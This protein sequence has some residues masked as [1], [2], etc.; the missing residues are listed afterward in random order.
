MGLSFKN[1][2]ARSG[3]IDAVI[4][5]GAPPL[6]PGVP[7]PALER[8]L[9]HGVAVFQSLGAAWLVPSGGVVGAPPAEAEIMRDLAVS[10]GVPDDRI[11]VEDRAKNTFENALYTGLIIRRRG[12]KSVVV[13]T[14]AFHMP[15]ALYVFR[16]LGLG[17]VGDP[18]RI[19][20]PGSLPTRLRLYAREALAF[21]RCAWL[22]RVGRHK[23]FV[24]AVLGE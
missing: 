18:V 17:V 14:D 1:M 2:S 24:A 13:V 11:V 10:K 22:F 6:G 12:W 23:P 8:R 19:R 20:Q 3:P 7:G 5:L 15:R 16:R 4:V 9:E 21:A